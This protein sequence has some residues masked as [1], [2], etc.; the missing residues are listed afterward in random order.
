[1][2]VLKVRKTNKNLKTIREINRI[3][4]PN[5]TAPLFGLRKHLCW[6]VVDDGDN[7]VGYASGYKR[8][9]FFYLSRSGILPEFRGNNLQK[10][11]IE[12]R[13]K[14]AKEN[15]YDGLMTHTSIDNI[16]SIKN[17]ISC[18]FD[19]WI[20]HPG[21]LRKYDSEQFVIWKMDIIPSL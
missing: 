14:Y 10:L 19:R 9:N 18:G 12:E 5:D 1:M 17:L 8:R 13:I 7:V 15:G 6:V 3:C 11:L 20:N 21:W 16:P 4:F 2:K